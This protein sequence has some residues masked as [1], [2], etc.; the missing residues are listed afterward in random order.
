MNN[1]KGRSA[2]M[3]LHLLKPKLHEIQNQIYSPIVKIIIY[4]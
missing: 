4:I 1:S 3:M 2:D